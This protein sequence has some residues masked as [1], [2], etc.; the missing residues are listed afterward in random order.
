MTITHQT[1]MDSDGNPTAALIPWDEFEAIQQ[2]LE[3]VNDAPLSPEWRAELDRRRQ[4]IDDGTT[5]GT[6]H[7]QAMDEVRQHLETTRRERESR[8]A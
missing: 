7:H 8:S 2:R 1:L 4:G 6:P 5:E 3:E